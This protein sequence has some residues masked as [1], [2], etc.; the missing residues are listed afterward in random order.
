M[1]VLPPG[2][3]L[4]TSPRPCSTQHYDVF[5]ATSRFSRKRPGKPAFVVAIHPCS[6]LP[7]LEQLAAAELAAGDVVVRHSTIEKGDICYYTVSQVSLAEI[8][9]SK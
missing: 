7:T 3:A 4:L 9:D 1:L 2:L 5:L 8:W 6:Q